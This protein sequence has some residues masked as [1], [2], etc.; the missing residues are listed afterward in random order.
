MAGQSYVLDK[1]YTIDDSGGV[2]QFV[3][4]VQGA[5]AGGCKKPTGANAGQFLGFTQE[6]QATQ[7]KGV[8]VRKLGISWAIAGSA[9]TAGD[10]V[11]IAGTTGKVE[12]AQT[13]A[14]AAPGTAKVNYVIGTAETAASTD[15]DIIQ[16]LIGPFVVKTAVS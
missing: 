1:T 3:A 8:S 13:D 9:I 6:A 14:I 4:V 7:N 12:S 5:A 2:G 11:R 15:G 16:V 10:Y